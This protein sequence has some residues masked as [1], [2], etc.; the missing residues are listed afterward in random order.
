MKDVNQNIKNLTSEE[1]V[2]I[3]LECENDEMCDRLGVSVKHYNDKDISNAKEFYKVGVKKIH[4]D[5]CKIKDSGI[6]FARLNDLYMSM[7]KCNRELQVELQG[8]TDITVINK[9]IT[10]VKEAK[11]EVIVEYINSNK[12][13]AKAL[14]LVAL[15]LEIE[16]KSNWN[17]DK[18][19][20]VLTTI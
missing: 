17:K 9:M 11:K 2:N 18:M 15:K 6:A 13:T 1:I 5:R 12:V 3:L 20:E 16:F 14:K 19:I 8:K 10:L 4:P 7:T